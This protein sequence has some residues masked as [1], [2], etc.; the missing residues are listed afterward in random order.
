M[1]LTQRFQTQLGYWTF[2]FENLPCPC[3]DIMAFIHLWLLVSALRFPFGNCVGPL[4]WADI[5]LHASLPHLSFSHPLGPSW[6]QLLLTQDHTF[7]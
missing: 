7:K 4:P 2:A 5:S 3:V 1:M 6:L